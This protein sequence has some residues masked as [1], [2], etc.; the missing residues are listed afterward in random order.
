[1][2]AL[3]ACLVSGATPA[4]CSGP[5]TAGLGIAE[6]LHFRVPNVLILVTG[7]TLAEAPVVKRGIVYIASKPPKQVQGALLFLA[8]ARS[9]RC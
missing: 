4:A 6:H 2:A 3:V 8:S 9:C 1:M 5:G 7:Y